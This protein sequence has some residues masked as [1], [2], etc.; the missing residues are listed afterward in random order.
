MKVFFIVSIEGNTGPS[1]ANRGFLEN[2]PE[3]DEVR[4]LTGKGRTAKLFR[5]VRGALWCDVVV[6]GGPGALTDLV[7][8][9][10]MVRRIPVVGYCHGYAPFENEV[11]RQGLSEVQMRD[12]ADWLDRVDV[13]A[14]NTELQKGFLEKHQPSLNG[15]IEITLLGVEPFQ[16]PVRRVPNIG[17]LIVAV[18]GGTRPIK[19]ND[20]VARAVLLLRG[21]GVDV[22]LRVYGRKYI[23]NKKLDTLVEAIGS[24]KGQVS[25][26]EFVEELRDVDVFVM[27]SR[28]ES[29]GLSAIDALAAG[30]SLLLSANCGV[31]EIFET[32]VCDV[33]SDCENVEEVAEKIAHLAKHP[34]CERLY[35]SIDFE[36]CSWTAASNRLRDVCM[37]AVE[38][39]RK[40]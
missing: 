13:V 12:F 40:G 8:L 6:S 31:K 4:L 28:H 1:N 18:S 5:A 9:I 33:V 11:N 16:V 15:K 30:C 17:R 19:G 26:S 27:N 22:V 37:H 14:T 36:S 20:V 2:W 21:K 25:Q 38:K 35:S 39:K 7:S 10:A 34:N 32:E 29:F 3:S 23:K 24:Y